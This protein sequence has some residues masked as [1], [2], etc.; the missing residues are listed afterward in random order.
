MII[1]SSDAFFI[2]QV[3]VD[4]K[5]CKTSR[6][7]KL[8]YPEKEDVVTWLSDIKKHNKVLEYTLD[9]QQIEVIRDTVGGSAWEIYYI[10]V[11]LFRHPLEDIVA[12]MKREKVAMVAVK[13]NILYYDPGDLETFQ[14]TLQRLFSAIPYQNYANKI[15]RNY[16]G[17]YASVVYP[18]PA[19][20]GL[21]L[22]PEDTT[23]KGRVDLTI[24][25]PDKAYVI[26]FKVDQPGKALEQIKS[27]GYHEKYLDDS[28]T[29]YVVGISFDSQEK[30]ITE[31][32][33]EQVEE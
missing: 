5:L 10:L 27:K 33:W 2:K 12:K 9:D 18:Y 21:Q 22:I 23:N 28:R 7:M 4:S 17:Y 11:E 3:Y 29:V 24:I 19:S 26:E 15:I 32:E 6:F 13:D 31:F 14:Q 16:E 1:A 8:D 20:L 25:L 30:T